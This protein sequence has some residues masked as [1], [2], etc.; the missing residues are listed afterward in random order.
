[1]VPP[2]LRQISPNLQTTNDGDVL[3]HVATKDSSAGFRDSLFEEK[4]IENERRHARSLSGHFQ[5]AT[6]LS[7]NGDTF[8]NRKGTANT[9]PVQ[10]ARI[11]SQVSGPIVGQK[12]RRVFSGD[13]SNPHL[14]HRRI[15]STGCA[16]YIDK[17]PMQAY[18]NKDP[19]SGSSSPRLEHHPKERSHRRGSSAGLDLLS[20]AAN[21]SEDESSRTKWFQNA[22]RSPV[23]DQSLPEDTHHSSRTYTNYSP[24][25]FSNDCPPNNQYP[26]AYNE[27]QDYSFSGNYQY[28]PSR[29]YQSTNDYPRRSNDYE[30][31]TTSNDFPPQ[32]YC[33]PP[34]E[35]GPQ[36][37]SPYPVQYSCPPQKARRNARIISGPP[38][39]PLAEGVANYPNRGGHRVQSSFSSIGSESKIMTDE[40]LFSNRNSMP[41]PRMRASSPRASPKLF[42]QYLRGSPTSLQTTPLP[43]LS[44]D[45]YI[46]SSSPSVEYKNQGENE[47]RN[48]SASSSQVREGDKNS[49]RH[50]PVSSV[51]S[52]TLNHIL[53]ELGN[54]VDDKQASCSENFH[55]MASPVQLSRTQLENSNIETQEIFNGAAAHSSLPPAG[56]FSAT[57]SSAKPYLHPSLQS[58]SDAIE[59]A[60][61]HTVNG[62]SGRRITGGVSKRVRRKCTVADCQNRVVQGGLCIS[63]GAKRK[64]CGHPGCKKHVKKAGM[65]SAHGPARKRCEFQDC[66]KVAVQGGRCIAHG[67]KKKL[68]KMESCKKQAI[69]AG[70]CKRHNDEQIATKPMLCIPVS[71]ELHSDKKR[72]EDLS[73]PFST[74]GRN[75]TKPTHQRGLSIFQDMSAVNTIINGVD[76][77]ASLI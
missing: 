16:A 48:C 77:V 49:S 19:K 22:R 12:H 45:G 70:M 74:S 60:N 5:D 63:H 31:H 42:M 25:N 32:T 65:C 61:K 17:H 47:F 6:K 39:H 46:V 11:V 27:N 14:A 24:V 26:N 54:N 43:P 50:R 1:M 71:C 21:V 7:G 28:Y 2:K 40:P 62:A 34:R 59:S 67:A 4:Q 10:E 73:V 3:Y 37:K 41:P 35:T 72:S 66:D 64:I 36:K 8:S 56:S 9:Y 76:T 52:G 30:F 51:S 38:E 13:V 55:V 57:T 58:A 20:V 15:D 53:G 44:G 68:C 29:N 18:P 33:P 23:F 75:V 69:L